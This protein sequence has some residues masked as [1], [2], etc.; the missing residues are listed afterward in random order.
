[1]CFLGIMLLIA[2]ELAFYSWFPLY[3]WISYSFAPK[4]INQICTHVSLLAITYSM[5]RSK[6]DYMYMCTYNC[7]GKAT[8]PTAASFDIIK[9]KHV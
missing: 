2:T 7:R 1:M 9:K 3:E 5:P 4:F 6:I 8:L